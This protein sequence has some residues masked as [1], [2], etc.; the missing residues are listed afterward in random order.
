MAIPMADGKTIAP[1]DKVTDVNVITSIVHPQPIKGLG[2]LVILNK[3][4]TPATLKTDTAASANTD[5]K[6]KGSTQTTGRAFSNTLSN[7]DRMNGILMR[8]VDTATGGLYR[9]YK[10]TDAV[11]TDYGS[12]TEV[13]KQAQAYFAQN[14]TSDRIA[15]I[16]YVADKLQETLRDFWTFNWTFAVLSDHT[17]SDETVLIS[18]IFEA[19]VDHFLVLQANGAA[20]FN[21]YYG[22]NYTIGL[23]H[24]I[25]EAMDAAFV[26]AI[27][28]RPV[29]SVT[30]KF[31]TLN[32]ITADNVTSN[33]RSG[34]D[35]AHVLGYINVDGAP[36][37]SE[38][39]TL[40][41]EYIDLLHGELWVKT[42]VAAKLVKLLRDNPKIPYDHNGIGMIQSTI[43]NVM[44]D[45]FHRQII[46]ER[47]ETGKGDYTV[48]VTPREEQSVADLSRRHYGGAS[49]EYHAASA[50]HTL[51][52][53]G[54]VDSDTL[55]N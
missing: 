42:N 43:E 40:S 8:K 16:D 31:K 36:E 9:E 12:D 37:T 14:Y 51:T 33:E 44:L 24:N 35:N 29:G 22:Q 5:G 7:D 39:F 54:V 15:V 55:L 3:V 19:N 23:V 48:T 34:M 52:V 27:A 11:E 13:Y 4:D 17:F 41:G 30:W 32:G 21:K 2:N 20:D 25:N 28:N 49:Y 53:K 10:N 26:G 6:D 18:N 50:V 46:A 1:F 47:G 38:G 45:G